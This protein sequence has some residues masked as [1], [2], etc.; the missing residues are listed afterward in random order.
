[1]EVQVVGERVSIERLC[2]YFNIL[3]YSNVATILLSILLFAEDFSFWKHAVSDLG[4]TVLE[5]GKT[6]YKSAFIF[7]V[8]MILCGIVCVQ[9]YKALYAFSIRQKKLKIVLLKFTSLGY[10]VIVTPYNISNIIHS[11]GASL[12]FGSLYLLAVVLL[13][14]V[15]DQGK[16]AKFVFYQV[17]LQATVIPYA[18]LFFLYLPARQSAQ[19]FAVAGLILSLYACT[20]KDVISEGVDILEVHS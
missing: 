1:M 10:F 8:G 18:V 14:E 11:L 4:T 7:S 6:N 19:K 13:L 20:R 17:L 3:L 12:V 16:K 2:N 15:K 5:D 9:I